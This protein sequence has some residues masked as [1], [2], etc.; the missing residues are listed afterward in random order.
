ML[1]SH[2]MNSSPCN[3]KGYSQKWGSLAQVKVAVEQRYSW[4]LIS[5][6]RLSHAHWFLAP[7]ILGSAVCGG[8]LLSGGFF[9]LK[10]RFP[11]AKPVMRQTLGQTTEVP[12]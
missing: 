5:W 4:Y 6:G 2:Q 12:S 8:A 11:W 1:N 9:F 10:L 3:T 7:S